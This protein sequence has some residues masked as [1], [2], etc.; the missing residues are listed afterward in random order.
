MDSVCLE[1]RAINRC[2]YI[3]GKLFLEFISEII[4]HHHSLKV[5]GL[6]I[7]KSKEIDIPITAGH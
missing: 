5:Y 7:S 2:V 4:E 6:A 3:I 1:L